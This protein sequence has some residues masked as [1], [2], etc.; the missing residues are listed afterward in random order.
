M[1]NIMSDPDKYPD[2]SI[3]NDWYNSYA[4]KKQH[5][6][7]LMEQWEEKQLELEK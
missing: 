1:D 4:N 2:V 5:L 3:D 6:H 7:D